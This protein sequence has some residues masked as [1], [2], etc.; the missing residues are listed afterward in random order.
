M[1]SIK[2]YKILTDHVGQMNSLAVRLSTETI[3]KEEAKEQAELKAK[4]L[5]T[6][7]KD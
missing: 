1:T 7:L 2:L 6:A 3:T 4:E 5:L